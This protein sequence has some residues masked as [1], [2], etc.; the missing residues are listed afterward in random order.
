MKCRHI[1]KE[2]AYSHLSKIV[3]FKWELC[4]QNCGVCKVYSSTKKVGRRQKRKHARGRPTPNPMYWCRSNTTFLS[5]SIPEDAVPENLNLK[6]FDKEINHQIDLCK[7][8]YCNDI[9]RRPICLKTCL[10]NFCFSC[11]TKQLEG[12]NMQSLACPTCKNKIRV[13][14]IVF[15]ITLNG[16]LGTLLIECKNKCGAKYKISQREESF[17]HYKSCCG[18]EKSF[19]LLDILNIDQSSSIPK[20]VEKA[21]YHVVKLKIASSNEPC[22]GIKFQS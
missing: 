17:L 9:Y 11:L 8:D 7:C 2:S 14:D 3:F 10:H 1:T 13:E 5:N 21:A 12:Q 4:S 20:E 15:S 16:I 18:P 6:S 19:R 22:K